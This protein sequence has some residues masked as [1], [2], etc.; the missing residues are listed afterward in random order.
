MPATRGVARLVPPT[1]TH[2]VTVPKSYGSYTATPVSGSASA[3]MSG[4][5]RWP[6]FSPAASEPRLVAGHAERLAVAAAA[7][8]VGIAGDA[9]AGLAVV[10]VVGVQVQAGAAD[11]DDLGR[12]R[13]VDD[14]EAVAAVAR[15]RE[16]G[17]VRVGRQRRLDDVGVP[18]LL[19]AGVVVEIV[20][21]AVADRDRRDA[22]QPGQGGDPQRDVLE[23]GRR[24]AGVVRGGAEHDDVGRRRHGVRPLDVQGDLDAGAPVVEVGVVELVVAGRIGHAVVV[25]ELEAGRVGQAEGGVELRQGAGAIVGV[26]GVGERR[27]EPLLED[28]DG[29]A[30]AVALDAGV[31]EAGVEAG[32]VADAVGGLDLD[33]GVAR[34]PDRL[35]RGAG[36]H[37]RGDR[38]GAHDHARDGPSV[39]LQ[40]AGARRRARA[41]GR[42]HA[43]GARHVQ[44]GRAAVGQRIGRQV[45][46][47]Q[48]RTRLA[49]RGQVRRQR[50]REDQPLLE[51]LQKRLGCATL[52]A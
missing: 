5:V 15:G 4:V 20:V 52:P 11:R 8:V 7:A 1:C 32:A 47:G 33:R 43:A 18:A 24:V 51:V 48:R 26:G 2:G 9:P 50:L 13:R 38:E 12:G 31:V 22:G 6:V 29:L 37:R 39:G 17:H 34:R 16:D 41:L 14:P 27:V 19:Q 44:P 35:L 30:G 46:L 23:A 49:Q 42:Q 10:R 45:V 36:Q 3:E 40:R 21:P 25:D 28:A